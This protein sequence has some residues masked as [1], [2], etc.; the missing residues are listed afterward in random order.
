[1]RFTPEVA[2]F[3]I[4][5]MNADGNGQTPVIHRSPLFDGEPVWSPD[6]TRLAF[7]SW[8]DGPFG[9]YPRI[10]I[11]NVDGTGVR[12]LTPDVDDN[13]EYVTDFG[14]SWS[15]DGTQIVFTR[16]GALH[17]INADGS[18]FAALP[19][20]EFAQNP[21]WSPD[22]TRIAYTGGAGDIRICDANGA[23]PVSVTTN[24]AQEFSPRWSPDGRRL[25]FV[26]VTD[27]QV[28]P[29]FV[30]QLYTINVDGTGESRLS[31]GGFSEYSP[32]WGPDEPARGVSGVQVEVTPATATLDVGESRQFSAI[33]RAHSGT[34]LSDAS[35]R[36]VS[37]NPAVAVVNTSGVVTGAARGAAQIS[38]EFGNAT[39]RARVTVAELTLRNR[40][41]F[42]TTERGSF[43]LGVIRSDGSDR[44][45]LTTGNTGG[46]VF[47]EPDISPDG[48][49]IAF[50]DVTND[51]YIMN[52][53]ASGI[54]PLATGPQFDGSPDW[55]PDG[56]RIAFVRTIPTPV[57]D[58]GRIFVINV[59]GTGLRQVSPEP[60]DPSAFVGDGWPSWAPDGMRLVFAR[61][62][63][64]FTVNAD[65]S[66]L[67][68]VPTPHG[69]MSPTWS[70]DGSRIA[71]HSL[72]FAGELFVT[73]PDGS[74]SVQL[75][76]G[77]EAETSP[78]WSPDSRR[79]VF[80]RW[81][82]G[83]TAQLWIINAD[84]TG[85]IR[86][87]SPNPAQPFAYDDD[88][89]WSPLP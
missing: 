78:G 69:A 25:V 35:V 2:G 83:I 87:T 61:N 13:L 23:N 43:D 46:R 53:D 40:I 65:G 14:P 76:D 75:T 16:N 50:R 63:E 5:V 26:R 44:H 18:G 58:Q 64:L 81:V 88:P 10:F 62:G 57:G 42:A 41:V 51:V 22:G 37:D 39:G 24:P 34:I 79:I 31:P 3:T 17:V 30:T 54:T 71:Y 66:G 85:L 8:K 89:S 7:S 9:P 29:D 73:K 56:T 12:Q 6:G 80:A 19:N 55:S 28:G 60:D 82:D 21:W 86:L 45:I 36:W 32:D 4:Y 68:P 1:P 47:L 20:E 72:G 15:P 52:A 74:N 48:R 49:R 27:D 67:T 38:A 70:P 77:P 11:V 84:G 33:V 59:D